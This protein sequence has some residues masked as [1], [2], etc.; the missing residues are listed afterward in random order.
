VAYRLQMLQ[1][2]MEAHPDR[3]GVLRRHVDALELGIET[4]PDLCLHRVRTLF[5]AV[6]ATIAPR[7]GVSLDDEMA[8]PA[9]NSRIIK[10]MDFSI[11]NHPHGDRINEAISKLLGSINGAASAL[12]ELSNIPNLRHGGSLD[13]STLQRQHAYMLG[14]FCDA[15]VTFLFDVAWSR[16]LEPDSAPAASDFGDFADF[17]RVLDEDHGPIVIANATFE[18]S[19]V[20]F[21]LD[22]TQYDAARAEWVPEESQADRENV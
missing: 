16:E 21:V 17:N 7:L 14:G 20:L 5:E 2:L 11:P 19:R 9:R 10:A 18:A 22:R 4:E 1:A 13:W 3:A 15:L 8:F 12:A 6:H